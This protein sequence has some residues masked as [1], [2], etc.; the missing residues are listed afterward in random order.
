[1]F[2]VFLA[3]LALVSKK[4]MFWSFNYRPIEWLTSL[5]QRSFAGEGGSSFSL[6]LLELQFLSLSLSART[7]L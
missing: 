3:Y 6:F 5:L 4:N 7:I 2:I 1:M